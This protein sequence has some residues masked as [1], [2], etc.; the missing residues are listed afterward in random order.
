MTLK[1]FKSLGGFVIFALL[2]G[3]TGPTTV[4]TYDL[5]KHQGVY[6]VGYTMDEEV[7]RDFED[8]MAEDLLAENFQVFKSYENLAD[9]TRVKPE[10][11]VSRANDLSALTIL[12]VNPVNA[13]AAAPPV[14]KSEVERQQEMLKDLRTHLVEAQTDYDPESV[15]NIDVR[16]FL[17]SDKP[18]EMVWSG[19]IKLFDVGE[20]AATLDGLSKMIVQALIAVRDSVV[21]PI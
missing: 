19:S 6:I 9:V 1:N 3:C 12:L 18:P 20:R 13:D 10:T 15:A 21:P 4:R 16:L 8:L 2:A 17:L 11:V 5:T 14:A 7:R